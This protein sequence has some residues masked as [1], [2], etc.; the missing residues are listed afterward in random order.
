M[1]VALQGSLM[2]SPR[3][4]RLRVNHITKLGT[5][6]AFT[7]PKN[8]SGC[9]PMCSPSQQN[10][11]LSVQGSQ[12]LAPPG[13]SEAMHANATRP[14]GADYGVTPIL[15]TPVMADPEERKASSTTASK[16]HTL[17]PRL[18]LIS[19][20]TAEKAMLPSCAA[21]QPTAKQ[22]PVLHQ[23][24]SQLSNRGGM[25]LQD[26]A[27]KV[28]SQNGGDGAP[29]PIW[30]ICQA[31]ESGAEHRNS[32]RQQACASDKKEDRLEVLKPN[33]KAVDDQNSLS[34][35]SFL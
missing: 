6:A 13:G 3:Q 11:L 5:S 17:V 2:S 19:P 16:H 28:F 29:G 21:E 26:P 20:Q 30:N 24:P 35:F 34:V 9:K 22:K 33:S 8:G 7:P 1:I 14:T 10:K 31:P 12:R 18:P 23:M 25:M 27:E 32:S 4:G 15:A